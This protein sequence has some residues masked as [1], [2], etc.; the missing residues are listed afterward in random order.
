MKERIYFSGLSILLGVALLLL[1]VNISTSWTFLRSSVDDTPLFEP[2]QQCWLTLCRDGN[3]AYFRWVLYALLAQNIYAALFFLIL[4]FRSPQ[5]SRFHSMLFTIFVITILF[6]SSRPLQL[7]I[8]SR[9]AASALGMIIT[10]LTL[11]AHLLSTIMLF[12]ASIAILTKL[13]RNW[14]LLIGICIIISFGIAYRIPIDQFLYYSNL[15]NSIGRLFELQVAIVIVQLC[16]LLNVLGKYIY[17]HSR[18]TRLL[19]WALILLVIAVQNILYL[20]SPLLII[21]GLL[22]LVMGSVLYVKVLQLSE[23]HY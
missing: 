8:I 21:I 22:A 9:D 2:I 18:S 23:T 1:V 16:T 12:I 15:T 14:F 17:N 11:F 4:I 20:S 10:R 13:R 6:Q 5:Y 3:P 19:L 7:M